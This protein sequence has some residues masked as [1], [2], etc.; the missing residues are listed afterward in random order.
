MAPNDHLNDVFQYFMP[1][2]DH[3][4]GPLWRPIREFSA[5]REILE[6]FD[7]L[8]DYGK[9]IKD[10]NG[11]VDPRFALMVAGRIQNRYKS[12]S[13]T[14]D[15]VME[16]RGDLLGHLSEWRARPV[17]TG[18]IIPWRLTRSMSILP[19]A[20]SKQHMLLINAWLREC[21]NHHDHSPSPS[22]VSLPKR[23]IDVG[24]HPHGPGFVR[25]LETNG[26][27][28][29]ARYIALSYRWR[30][31]TTNASTTKANLDERLTA[32]ELDRLPRTFRDVVYIARVLRVRFV[33][34]DSLCILQ[35]KDGDWDTEAA[36]MGATY[37]SAY[38]TIAATAAADGLF[39][40]RAQSGAAAA[41]SFVSVEEFERDLNAG[42]LSE[43]GWVLQER[44]LS[45]RTIHFTAAQTYWECE[46]AIWCEASDGEARPR[47]LLSTSNI[48]DYFNRLP[49]AEARQVVEELFSKFSELSLTERTDQP[50]AISEL[51]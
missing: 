40:P 10:A 29:H 9:V 30:A 38:L 26:L 16:G 27:V 45:R 36:E 8:N 18:S 31:E 11:L 1:P 5:T 33:W 17:V 50:L 46:S 39:H 21:D 14:F 32:I 35:G 47:G 49:H 22:D 3:P 44:C 25:L 43:R 28:V 51:E 6:E 7:K 37:A 20:G 2:N 19:E 42:E 15:R 4:N 12:M 23:V 24:E 48:S 41:S 13:T 34:I